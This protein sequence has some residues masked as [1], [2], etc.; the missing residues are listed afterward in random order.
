RDAIAGA[1]REAM[2]MGAATLDVHGV[3][4][5]E[6]DADHRIDSGWYELLDGEG[7][8]LVQMG[9]YANLVERADDGSWQIRWAVK[10]EG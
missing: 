3:S 9:Y 4:T 6:L 7:G 10:V 5:M 1:A 2:E 8:E